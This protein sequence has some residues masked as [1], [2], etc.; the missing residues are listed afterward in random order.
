VSGTFQTRPLEMEIARGRP[1]SFVGETLAARM[2]ATSPV[3]AAVKL[4]RWMPAADPTQIL[5]QTL[6]LDRR[7]DPDRFAAKLEA[8]G[9]RADL[10]FDPSGLVASG[11]IAAGPEEMEVERVF[12]GGAL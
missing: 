10:V 2:V 11:A 7:V 5:E 1:T 3:G 9:I 12:S 4:Q 6:T 8:A